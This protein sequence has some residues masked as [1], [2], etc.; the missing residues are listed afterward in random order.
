MSISFRL[1]L[2]VIAAALVAAAAIGVPL[3]FGS[4]RL[5]SESA[6]REVSALDNKLDRA[7]ADAVA[8]ARSLAEL[9]A[10]T[11]DV[12]AAMAE[13]DRDRLAALYGPGFEAMRDRHGV[14]QFQ[15]HLP[16]ATSF[17]R[18]HKL[19][20]FGDDL[21]GFRFTVIE[22]NRTQR[23][24]AGLE[25]GRGGIGVRA[26]EPVFHGDRHVGT[27]EFGLDFSG[28]FFETL[29]EGTAAHA[30]FYLFPADDVATFS[31]EDAS[32]ARQAA[33]FDG[34][35][36]LDAAALQ[37]I[38]AGERIRAELTIDG[39]PFIGLA[40]P[41]RD[42][43]GRVAGVAH[44][45]ASTAALAATAGEVER[46]ALIAA[47]AAL[48]LTAGL[49][50][51]FSR[52]IARR[53]ERITARMSG[54][55]KGD[56]DAPIEGLGSRDEIGRMAEALEVFRANAADVARLREE[57]ALAEDAA[58]DARKAMV[59]RLAH[60]IGA[61]VAAVARGDF[62]RRVTCDFDEED[63]NALGRSV[64]DLSASIAH[65][66]ESVRRVMAA[67]AAGDLSQRMSGTHGGAFAALQTDLNATADTLSEILGAIGGAVTALGK[68]AE[69]MAHDS[70]DISERANAQAASLEETSATMEQMSATVSSN[71]Q[72][73]EDAT[74]RAVSVAETSRRS[75]AAMDGLTR[76]MEAISGGSEQIATITGTIESIATQTNLLALNAAV[77]AA[78]AG[79]AGKGFAVVAAEVRE[80]AKRASQAASE[81]NGLISTSR[82]DVARGVES[83]EGARSLLDAMATEIEGLEGLI[84]AI[85]SASREQSI[86]VSEVSST[87]SSLDQVTQENSRIAVHSEQVAETLQR[88]TTRLEA[89]AERFGQAR[90]GRAA[91]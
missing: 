70:H 17:L 2:S 22:A 59:R 83:V 32:T 13:G 7:L 71:A 88:E 69:D 58:R 53:L 18:V 3:L 85:S 84:A 63:L 25:R 64:N 21:S 12:G 76:Q 6:D 40:R 15:F 51:L 35:P 43:S 47:A 67:L 50:L 90:S 42:Y 38:R 31:T 54:L 56:L 77:E 5:I 60:E 30:E 80:L 41:I 57:Q 72:A 29:T 26:V 89:L 75:R 65:S 86:A 91:A 74:G 36:L 73:A 11:P 45:L 27:V 9:V 87:V 49:A 52:L 10:R 39:E 24:V 19:D 55:A 1:I 68:T 48:V 46:N 16:P 14:R 66:I 23:P 20:K 34:P 33:T 4:E 61:V 37:S 81:I 79:E 62:D 82:S 44:V 8:M 28:A 78:R